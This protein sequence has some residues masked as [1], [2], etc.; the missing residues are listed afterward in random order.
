[1]VIHMNSV[2]SYEENQDLFA[3]RSYFKNDMNHNLNSLVKFVNVL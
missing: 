1:M 2:L 3:K